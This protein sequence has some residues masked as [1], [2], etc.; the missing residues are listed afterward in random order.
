MSFQ[1]VFAVF[2]AIWVA[3]SI[4][5]LA[6]EANPAL[7][8]ALFDLIGTAVPGLIDRAGS[9]GAISEKA[10]LSTPA[11]S[12]TGAIALAGT[13]FTAV[14]WL[15]SARDAVRDL[16][17]LAAPA[18]N[19]ALL[20]LKDLGLAIAFGAALIVS[21]TL[22]VFSTAA[23]DATLDLLDVD[24]RSL[25][26]ILAARA[27]G[28]LLM[29]ALDA[30]VLAALYRVLAGVP[31]PRGPLWQ[32]ALLGALALG[33][34]KVLGSSL[35]GGATRNPLLASF[36]VIV[37]LLIW[38]NLICQV[39]LIAASWVIVTATDRGVPLDPIGERRARNTEVRLRIELERQIRREVEEALP[40]GVRWFVR[41]RH[42]R[43]EEGRTTRREPSRPRRRPPTPADDGDRP[44]PVRPRRHPAR[45]R[46]RLARRRLLRHPVAPGDPRPS[47]LA[48]LEAWPAPC[49]SRP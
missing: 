12:W 8:N 1:A 24:R 42:R 45:P 22:S 20:K 7:R 27:V 33:V 23:M 28:L 41:R 46:L 18:T 3:F 21:A 6:L 17:G 34:L 47:S 44:R 25:G 15:G 5:G 37:G 36:A 14:G 38:F 48:S 19:F 31:I 35:L 10:L 16:A 2:A 4:A 26:A 13:L 30:C 49:A 39:I 29:F 40:P 9:D 32:G 11:L 43:I